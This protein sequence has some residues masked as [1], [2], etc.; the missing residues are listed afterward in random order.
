MV[1]KTLPNVAFSPHLRTPTPP[2]SAPRYR[3]RPPPRL[4]ILVLC[5][6]FSLAHRPPIP[7]RP[8]ISRLILINLDYS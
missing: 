6:G 7:I 1:G 3:R 8:S 2:T 4:D 5:R